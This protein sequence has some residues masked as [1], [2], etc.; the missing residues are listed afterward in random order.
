MTYDDEGVMATDRALGTHLCG[1]LKRPNFPNA[2]E[3]GSHSSEFQQ[4]GDSR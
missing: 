1:A 2:E 3:S 4:L